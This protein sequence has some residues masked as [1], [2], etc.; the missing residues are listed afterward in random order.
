MEVKVTFKREHLAAISHLAAR[1][2]VWYYINSIR[3]EASKTKTTLFGTTGYFG[4]VTIFDTENIM[5]DTKVDIL[6]PIEVVEQA[7]KIADKK[8]VIFSIEQSNGSWVINLGHT[9]L[10]FTPMDGRKFEWKNRVVPR[11]CDGLFTNIDPS[12]YVPFIKASKCLGYGSEKIRVCMDSKVSTIRVDGCDHFFGFLSPLRA[13][14][15]DSD[16]VA[17]AWVYEEI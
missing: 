13:P 15:L 10:S 1:K 2:D 12:L 11:V 3:V 16:R 4:G 9:K 8:I 7:L 17:P 14:V 6:I 5:P